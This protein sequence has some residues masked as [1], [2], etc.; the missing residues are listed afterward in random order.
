MV[1]V[2]FRGN[3]IEAYGGL[4]TSSSEKGVKMDVI[5]IR[6]S[7]L[8]TWPSLYQSQLACVFFVGSCVFGKRC[9][10][11]AS[12]S[13]YIYNTWNSPIIKPIFIIKP[14][15]NLQLA[16]RKLQKLTVYQT[17]TNNKQTHFLHIAHSLPACILLSPYKEHNI[18]YIASEK[19][20]KTRKKSLKKS[21]LP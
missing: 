5:S 7:L 19:N 14:R 8:E 21:S 15:N 16:N 10:T 17:I 12:A 6:I 3:S 1:V 2:F 11:L 4:Q 20:E 13:T 18:A 9:L